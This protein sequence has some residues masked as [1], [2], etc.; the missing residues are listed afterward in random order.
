VLQEQQ[1]SATN[2]HPALETHVLPEATPAAME[3]D[4][5]S[6]A[7]QDPAGLQEQPNQDKDTHGGTDGRSVMMFVLC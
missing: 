7:N 1:L 6:T 2:A 5:D 4:V 3:A